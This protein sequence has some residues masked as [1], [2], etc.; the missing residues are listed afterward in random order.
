M[1][2]MFICLDKRELSYSF[3]TTLLEQGRFYT[4]RLANKTKV[5]EGFKPSLV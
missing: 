4:G 5:T 3:Y 2:P 1:T